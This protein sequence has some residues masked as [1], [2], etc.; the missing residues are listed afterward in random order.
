MQWLPYVLGSIVLVVAGLQLRV[1]IASRR[2][3]G[4]A[5]PKLDTLLAPSQRGY[6]RYL[7]Y[8][9]SPRCGPCRRMG[10]R[11]DALAARHSNV[12]KVDV[13]TDPHLA[14]EFGIMA[15]PTIVLVRG[16]TIER[17]LLGETSERRVEALLG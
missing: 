5:A 8:F 10:P 16:D 14:R 13:S 12:L 15:T 6:D 17:V 2:L 7:V 9:F 11:V 4:H 3:Q 1:F